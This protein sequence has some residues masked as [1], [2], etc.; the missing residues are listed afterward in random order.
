[1]NRRN[2]KELKDLLSSDSSID[3]YYWISLLNFFDN[4]KEELNLKELK[5]I[6]DKCEE[7]RLYLNHENTDPISQEDVNP[8]IYEYY[9][10]QE[11]KYN[12]NNKED[13]SVET[14]CAIPA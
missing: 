2:D 4:D 14:L 3:F 5:K 10:L 12:K 8:N 9:R 13:E 11:I 7:C 6:V 1:V